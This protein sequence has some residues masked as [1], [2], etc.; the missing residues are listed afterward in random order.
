MYLPAATAKGVVGA[1]SQ[2]I[3]LLAGRVRVRVSSRS[4]PASNTT[5]IPKL[6]AGERRKKTKKQKKKEF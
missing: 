4:R 1:S 5:R 2:T 3:P 6:I